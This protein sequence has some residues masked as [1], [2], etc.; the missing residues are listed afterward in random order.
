MYGLHGSLLIC[1]GAKIIYDSEMN[2]KFH[3]IFKKS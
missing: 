3:S 2:L 1:Y